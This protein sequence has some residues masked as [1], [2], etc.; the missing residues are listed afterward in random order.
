MDEYNNQNN[1]FNNN[2]YPNNQPDY[3][4]QYDNTYNN[5]QPDY[6]NQYNQAPADFSTQYQSPT[7]NYYGEQ[8]PQKSDGKAIASLVLGI[9]GVVFSCCC[10]GYISSIIGLIL[11]IVSKSQRPNNNGM[12][13]AGIIVSG[14]AILIAIGLLIYSFAVA[15]NINTYEQFLNEFN[16][17][18]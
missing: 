10:L 6:S 4:A 16:G 13:L 14:A 9:V 5:Q 15:G 18:Y 2:P 17:Y 11:G 1:G 8:M 3:N 12:A 7:P